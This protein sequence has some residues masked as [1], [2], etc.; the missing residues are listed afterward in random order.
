MPV[1]W[2]VNWGHNLMSQTKKTL[3]TACSGLAKTLNHR[4]L[5]LLLSGC[6]KAPRGAP[7]K[8]C[9]M[10]DV[11]DYNRVHAT[12][13]S[14]LRHNDIIFSKNQCFLEFS[15][16]FFS[17]KCQ[18]SQTLLIKIAWSIR[19]TINLDFSPFKSYECLV[20]QWNIGVRE[21]W[22]AKREVGEVT[23][24]KCKN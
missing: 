12:M 7:G 24:V 19:Q 17:A 8:W 16:Y 2:T 20:L 11:I 15:F 18:H 10:Y 4:T 21:M 9:M 5:H 23:L 13:T 1:L 14:L 6:W 22:T 3:W